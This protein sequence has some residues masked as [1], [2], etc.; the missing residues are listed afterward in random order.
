MTPKQKEAWDLHLQGVSGRAIAKRLGVSPT[1]IA[2]RL[3]A[4]RK[5]LDAGSAIQD[6]MSSVGMT[7]ATP[8]HSG[9]I[10][11]EDVSLYFQMPKDQA[12]GVSDIVREAFKDIPACP[13]IPIARDFEDGLLTI[14]PIFDAHIGMRASAHDSGED[15][16]NEIAER[17]ITG[18][19]GQCVA[20]SPSSEQAVVL[21]GGDALHANDQTAMTPKSKHVLDVASSFADAVDVAIR[22]FAACIEMAAAKH[23]RVL[24]S[25]IQGNHDRDAYLSILYALRERY[26]DN[27]HIEVQRRGGEFFVMEWGSVMLVSHHGDKAK[28]E[29]LV[30]HMADE[31]SEMWGRTRFRFYF[32]GHMHHTKM[33]DIGGVQ[34]EQLRAAAPRDAYAA[35]HAYSSRS[36]LQAITYHKNSGEVSRVRVALGNKS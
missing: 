7:D 18:G 23:K 22:T 19:I 9:W 31:W 11:S 20:S 29:R 30:M 21:I 35:T 13:P 12:E 34:V 1:N 27:P 28:A 14:Y 2:A 24:V 25:V 10:K 4:A 36:E 26:R 3:S 15:M 17:R 33:Q 8:L 32:T 6:A 5:Y 16:D